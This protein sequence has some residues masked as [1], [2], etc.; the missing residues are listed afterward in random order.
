M[1]TPTV[2]EIR[3]NGNPVGERIELGRY[4]VP[5]D[6]RV[7]YDFW[8]AQS[9]NWRLAASIMPAVAVGSEG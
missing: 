2:T 7:L 6:E 1:T 9:S 5:A 3:R 4:S 8:R